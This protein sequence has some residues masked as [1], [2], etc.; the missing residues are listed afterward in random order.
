MTSFSEQVT[1]PC[2]FRIEKYGISCRLVNVDDADFIF[3]L[4][5]DKKLTQYLHK[6]DEDVEKQRDWIRVY[7][8]REAEGKDYY[9]IYSHDGVPFA[10]NRIYN[11]CN[12]VCTGGSWICKP[13]T[14]TEDAIATALINRDIMFEV[15]KLKADNFEVCKGNNQVIKFHKMMGC[16]KTGE[17]NSEISFQATPQTYFPKRDKIINLLNIGF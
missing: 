8:T 11:I 15:L 16:L 13:G 10:L 17:S 3:S 4:R 9:F 2:D 14:R 6:I 12:G 7:K 5:T 1:L